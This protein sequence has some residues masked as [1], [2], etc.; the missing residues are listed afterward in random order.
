[1]RYGGTDMNR[2]PREDF[3]TKVKNVLGGDGG[4]IAIDR[5]RNDHHAVNSEGMNARNFDKD[6]EGPCGVRAG[7]LRQNGLTAVRQFFSLQFRN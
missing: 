3:W 7:A 1:M 4:I 2:R 6:D 5:F